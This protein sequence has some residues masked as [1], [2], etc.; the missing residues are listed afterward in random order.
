MDYDGEL[1]MDKA[2]KERLDLRRERYSNIENN[3]NLTPGRI[4][5]ESKSKHKSLVEEALI[6]QK[7]VQELEDEGFEVT[8][9]RPLFSERMGLTDSEGNK[10]TED[11]KLPR[12]LK[13]T[14]FELEDHIQSLMIQVNNLEKNLDMMYWLCFPTIIAIILYLIFFH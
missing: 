12:D 10:L 7:F 6:K 8:K 4:D 1:E 11:D 3:F 9:K 5:E 13:Y 2:S 14:H